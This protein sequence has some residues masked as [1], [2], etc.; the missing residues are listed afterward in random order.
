MIV[1]V[2]IDAGENQQLTVRSLDNDFSVL[3]TVTDGSVSADVIVDGSDLIQ[4]VSKCL[5]L[6]ST[7]TT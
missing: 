7:P 5:V 2:T 4:A 3:L 1:N 6:E